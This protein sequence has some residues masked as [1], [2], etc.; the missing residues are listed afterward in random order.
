MCERRIEATFSIQEGGVRGT[1]FYAK[2][3]PA[4]AYIHL[5]YMEI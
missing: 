1:L 5:A 2:H 3:N 4:H